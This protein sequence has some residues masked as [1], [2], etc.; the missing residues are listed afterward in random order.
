MGPG[1]DCEIG[2]GVKA[3]AEDDNCEEAGDVAGEL[4]ILPLAGLS[5]RRRGP[6]EEVA[7][8]ALLVA[9]SEERVGA[10]SSSSAEAGAQ[11]GSQHAGGVR[12]GFRGRHL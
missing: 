8:G 12:E 2:L 9:G 5:R 1:L 3:D 10:V 6:A 4:P 11:A 7:V